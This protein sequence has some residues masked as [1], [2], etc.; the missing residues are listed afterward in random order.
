MEQFGILTNILA[1]LAML[2]PIV[3]IHEFGHYYVARKNNVT[4]DVFS[5]GFGPELYH[6]IDKNG[7]RWRI[8]ALPLGGYVKMRGDE[9]AASMM[10]ESS[11]AI[12]GS[13]ASA[14]LGARMA[15]VAAGPAMNF[16]TGILLF[17]LIYMAVG[18]VVLAPVVGQVSPQSPAQV[19]GLEA[20]DVI[21]AVN[22]VSIDDFSS[23][24]GFVSENPNK[25]L[26]FTV[27]RDGDLLNLPVIPEERCSEELRVTYGFLGVHS[28]QGEL[29]QLGFGES[30]AQGFVDTI[31]FSQAML[32]GI[33]R[34]VTGQ[35]NR[36]EIG[37]PVKI[38]QIS[39][40][41]ARGGWV[42]FVFLAGII[43]LNLGL[44]NLLPIPA[45]DGGHL[46]LFIVEGIIRRPLSDKV[47]SALLRAGSAF[48]MSAMLLLILYD[49]YS[50]LIPKFCP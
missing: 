44:V 19:A 38:A 24:K 37:G 9:N 21:T 16:L 28:I 30:I 10:S 35:M 25:E 45:L 15:I 46:M 23:L 3:F 17:A 40:D 42:S 22:G 7:T 8:A 34:M 33:G 11:R 20:G 12:K 48:L 31:A 29:R 43:S 26:L 13:F 1:L 27:D 47:Q 41:A 5:V 50:S 32:R 18:K 2:T 36:G 49:S 39:G 6:W 14:S 4:V